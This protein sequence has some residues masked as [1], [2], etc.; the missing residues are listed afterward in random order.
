MRGRHDGPDASLSFRHGGKCYAGA[1]HAFLEQ[2]AR[3]LHGEFS[4]ANDDGSDWSFTRRSAAPSNI[5]SQQVEFFFPET[6]VLP[7]SFHALRLVLENIESGDAS[8]RHRWRMR[9]R[10]QER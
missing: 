10:K 7:K 8:R 6:R 1:E 5:K 2:F 9:G 3:K 4:I